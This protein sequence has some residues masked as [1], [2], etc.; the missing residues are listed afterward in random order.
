MK[1]ATVS[2]PTRLGNHRFSSA[3]MKIAEPYWIAAV[4][5]ISPTRLNQPVNQPQAGPPSLEAQ[6]Y[7][8]PAVG[9]DEAI[10]PIAIATSTQN[11][12]TSSQPQVTA[13]GPPLLNAM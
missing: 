13:T 4:T 5:A 11:T 12:P 8:P 7:S 10:S 6:K 2:V 1:I 9:I 3:V